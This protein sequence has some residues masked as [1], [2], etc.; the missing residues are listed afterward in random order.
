[1]N[2]IYTDKKYTKDQLRNFSIKF[3]N[4]ARSVKNL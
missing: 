2:T 3:N 1:M 4:N